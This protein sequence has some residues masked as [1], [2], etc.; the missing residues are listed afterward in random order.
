[1][2]EFPV[3]T[4]PSPGIMGVDWE[5]RVD[6]E[7]LRQYRLAR[8]QRMLVEHDL[9]AVLLFETSNIRYATATQIGYWAFN[10]G[11]RWALVTRDGRPKVWDFGSAAKAHRLQLPHMYDTENSVGGNTGSAGRHRPRD[12]PPCACRARDQGCTRRCRRRHG[13]A[14]RRSRRDRRVPRAAGCRTECRRWPAG[15][16]DGPRDQEL[17]RDHPS[18]AGL[19][20]GRRRLPEH[21]RDAQTGHAGVRHRRDG[22]RP[23]LRD[24]LGVRRGHQLDRRRALFAPPARVLRPAHPP[25]RPGVLRHHPRLQWLPH[26]LLPHVRRRS[27]ESGS[28]R[29]LQAVPRV[30]G[31]RD[32]PRVDRA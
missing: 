16:D 12:R 17:R 6:F 8:V 13:A 24:G 19:R 32:R 7:R 31:C 4:T 14:R 30:D 1:M 27:G 29:C 20:D 15:D 18:H 3:A 9:G 22:P 10:K 21:L 26:L 5:N 2:A 11:E 25:G 23:A 28:A